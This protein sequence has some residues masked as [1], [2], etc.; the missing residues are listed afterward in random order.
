MEG[1]KVIGSTLVVGGGVAG[2]KAALDL[3]DSG[4]YV[5]LLEKEPAIGGIMSQL[6][7]TFPTIDCSMC[8]LAP[9]LVET[10]RHP[11]IELVTYSRIEKVEGKEGAFRVSVRNKARSIK[12]EDCTGCRACVD[13]CPVE[14]IVN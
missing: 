1:Q 12:L 2:V 10:A 3:A 7:K 11:N 14:N 9:Y 6:D 5:Y 4:Y 8:I 13:A